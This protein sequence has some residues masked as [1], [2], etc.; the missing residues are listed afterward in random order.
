MKFIISMMKVVMV[1]MMMMILKDQDNHFA[2]CNDVD[3]DDH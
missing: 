1:M 3:D 2:V